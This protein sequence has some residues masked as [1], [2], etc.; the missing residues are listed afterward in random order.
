MSEH[1]M[2]KGEVL[3]CDTTNLIYENDIMGSGSFCL[4]K[5]EK[6]KQV[7]YTEWPELPL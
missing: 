7:D 5:K 1:N 6:K 2:E 4:G 3:Y